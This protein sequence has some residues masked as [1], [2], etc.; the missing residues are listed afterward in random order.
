MSPLL[1]LEIKL[2]QEKRKV[3]RPRHRIPRGMIEKCYYQGEN[4]VRDVANLLGVSPTTIIK[5]MREYKIK[6]KRMSWVRPDK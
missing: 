6:P 2:K 4:T 5:L 1:F 3:G